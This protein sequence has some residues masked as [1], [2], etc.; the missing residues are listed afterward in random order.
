[1][2]DDDIQKRIN[3]SVESARKVVDQI[4]PEKRK[5]YGLSR[6][7]QPPSDD[8]EPISREWVAEHFGDKWGRIEIGPHRI[9]VYTPGEVDIHCHDEPLTRGQFRQLLAALGWRGEEKR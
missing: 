3:E 4:P 1:M 8:G 6:Y 9:L 7:N 5:H 2:S